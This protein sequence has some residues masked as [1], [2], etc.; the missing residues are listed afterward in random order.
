MPKS[1]ITRVTN[2]A[3]TP[4]STNNNNGFY[5][6]QLTTTLRN[7]IPASV[8]VNGALIYNTTENQLQG[9]INGAWTEI[10]AGGVADF[11][12]PSAGTAPTT[13]VNGQ[14]YYD[15]TTNQ[16]TA[17]IDGAWKVLFSSTDLPG[18]L[19]VPVVANTGALPAGAVAGMIVYQTDINTFK[20][21]QEGVWA[22]L[23]GSTSTATGAGLA[24]GN[25]AI[26]YPSGSNVTVEVVD[27]EV[28][29]FT[30][31]GTTS[32]NLRS[33]VNSGWSTL[34]SSTTTATGIG[35]TTAGNT[36]I[37]YPSGPSAAVEVAA[38]EVDGFVYYNTTAN[39]LRGR[40]NGTWVTITVA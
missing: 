10:A 25:Q 32:N 11:V 6:P 24:A 17:Y 40:V 4:T 9:Y 37:V 5:L 20:I 35:L 8:I 38:N 7:A 16:V 27:N 22:I 2:L 29:G 3:I 36:P 30:Y 33:R 13:P 26:T 1:A 14:I 18:F 23:L 19:V 12:A 21:Y 15:T 31:Y 39:N 28:N 34:V